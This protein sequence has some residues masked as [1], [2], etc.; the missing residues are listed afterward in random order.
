MIVFNKTLGYEVKRINHL[1]ATKARTRIK[2][3]RNIVTKRNK[4]FLR[5]LGFKV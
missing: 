5:S 2:A 3:N 4:D 1:P